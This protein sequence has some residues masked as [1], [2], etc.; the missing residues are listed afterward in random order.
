MILI[1]LTLVS[2]GIDLT[3][4]LHWLMM[5]KDQVSMLMIV[6]LS[7]TFDII[8]HEVLLTHLQILVGMEWAAL[9]FSLRDLSV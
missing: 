4:R 5:N 1:S 3:Q 7:A 9:F 6:D 2:M 8:G